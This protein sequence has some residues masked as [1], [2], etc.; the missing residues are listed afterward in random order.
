MIKV[1]IHYLNN[2]FTGHYISKPNPLI[3]E[4]GL[5]LNLRKKEVKIENGLKEIIDILK[6]DEKTNKFIK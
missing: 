3:L 1:K 4:K 2:K 6:K 5:I